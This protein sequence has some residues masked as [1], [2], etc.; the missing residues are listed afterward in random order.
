MAGSFPASATFWTVYTASKRALLPALPE[1]FAFV[2]HAASSTFAELAVCTVRTPFEVVKQQLQAGL[3]ASTSSAVTGILRVDGLRGF[4][5]GFGS[6]C[7]D[8]SRRVAP[9]FDS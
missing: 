1:S 5:A 6:T 7:E 9:S 8:T 2:A 3:H 4:Y